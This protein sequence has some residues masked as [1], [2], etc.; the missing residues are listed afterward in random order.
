MY[1][2]MIRED[3]AKLGFAGVNPR[4]VEAWMRCRYG[5]LDA[6]SALEF[7]SE[8]EIA[9]QCIRSCPPSTS[10]ALADSYGIRA[11]RGAA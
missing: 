4:H 11:V 8:V 5:T 1:Q 3:L 6:L 2:Q 9:V 10:E 7:R